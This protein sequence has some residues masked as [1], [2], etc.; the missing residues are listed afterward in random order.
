MAAHK[1][2]AGC[3]T[4]IT[5]KFAICI[6]C[7]QSYGS[8]PADWPEWLRFLWNDIQRERRRNKRHAANEIEFDFIQY[9]EIAVPQSHRVGR[10]R[11]AE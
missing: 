5:N 3:G 6:Q 7:E 2:L 4:T 9:D 8:R 11:G 10:H 1:C